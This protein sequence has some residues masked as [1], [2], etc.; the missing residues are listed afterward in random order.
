MEHFDAMDEL[1]R[2][3]AQEIAEHMDAEVL[4]LLGPVPAGWVP[5]RRPWWWRARARV[6][7]WWR[8]HWRLQVR[9]V[10]EDEEA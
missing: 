2:R 6:A 10:R 7:Q 5:P 4:A 9:W 3:R 1:T 8:K